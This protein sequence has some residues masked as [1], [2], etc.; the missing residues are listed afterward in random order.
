MAHESMSYDEVPYIGRIHF[1]S[2]V[3][4][5]S[6]IAR[7]FGM[8]PASPHRCRVL[9]IGC[10][11]GSNII[12]MGY[13]LP[14]STFIGIDGSA[15]QIEHGQTIIAD[16]GL[17][18]VTLK[19]ADLRDIGE[20]LGQFDY[21]IAHGIFSWIAEDAR[22]ALLQ[23]CRDRLTPEGVAYISY[24]TYPGWHYYEQL[25]GM[26][27][28][29]SRGMSSIAEEIQQ[30]RAI[31]QFVGKAII[32]TDSP[33]AAFF[34]SVVPNIL[35]M[36]DDYVYHEY[37]ELNNRPMYFYE[38]I[39]QAHQHD[40]QYLGESNFHSMMS[41]NYPEKVAST[42]EEISHNILEL[43]QYM[44]F[45][46]NRRFRCTLLCREELNLVRSIELEPLK[47][48][49]AAFWFDPAEP[50]HDTT[51]KGPLTF[52]SPDDTETEVIVSQPLHK[53][54]LMLMAKRWPAA[55]PFKELLAEATALLNIEPTDEVATDIAELIMQ[56]YTQS[57]TELHTFQAPM[58]NHVEESPRA[59]RLARYQAR[60]CRVLSS[61]KHH[62]VPMPDPQT[63]E[64]V[65]RL[66]GTRT[67]PE[68]AA[69]LL[70]LVDDAVLAELD[71]PI[72]ALT[73][74]VKL[75]LAKM[76]AKGVLVPEGV[77]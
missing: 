54:V 15:P 49:K 64:V 22:R 51:V 46:R 1:Q 21:I 75:I 74:N 66:D 33:R 7:L 38:F 23:L 31:V 4:A 65:A 9:E 28:F 19:T 37:L 69:E 60:H 62:M 70:P 53:T 13:H 3:D 2:H 35:Q 56:L 20:E 25:R 59:T 55:V 52:S 57:F 76:A 34:K 41:S 43:E 61:Q 5:L 45:L 32:D 26:M 27:R 30:A 63:R 68:L 6:T 8:S 39:G 50:D 47:E 71:D 10:A 77:D 16:L 58:L 17:S 12:T 18:N 11:D 67:I 44:D 24:N 14:E 36:S 48:M 73:A 72:A 40:L 29:H 42:L